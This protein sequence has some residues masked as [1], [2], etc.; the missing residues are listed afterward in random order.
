MNPAT[1]R[2]V[3]RGLGRLLRPP[4]LQPPLD[5]QGRLDAD[6]L[7]SEGVV[8][9][10]DLLS[11][12]TCARLRDYFVEKPVFDDYRPEVPPFLPLG[13][14]R[15]PNS[16]VAF[17]AAEDVLRAPGLLDLANHPR[18]LSIVEDVLG[19]RPTISYLAAW[20]SYPT[21]AGRA[22]GGEFPPRR[23]RLGVPQAVRLPHRCR[24]GFG[25]ACLCP[26]FG[27]GPPADGPPALRGRGSARR[28]WQ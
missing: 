6:A 9:L 26:Q 1:R 25:S 14:G 27:R 11:R 13:E 3:A 20:W 8:V 23:R 15:H 17:H 21:Q 24:R 5:A 16:H 12:E 22:A 18:I 28:L 7:D 4:P 19:F 10:G 2:R